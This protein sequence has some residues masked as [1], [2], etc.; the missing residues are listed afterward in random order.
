[1]PDKSAID[2]AGVEAGAK[3]FVPEEDES[4]GP[5]AH[6]AIT[7]QSRRSIVRPRNRSVEDFVCNIGI[8]LL[9]FI[10]SEMRAI[11]RFRDFSLTLIANRASQFLPPGIRLS[12]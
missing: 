5:L 8:S 11:M 4:F 2:L 10:T 7:D 9:P 1:L 6:T 12:K 3:I